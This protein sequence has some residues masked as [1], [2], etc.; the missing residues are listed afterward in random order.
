M[1]LKFCVCIEWLMK[2]LLFSGKSDPYCEVSMGTQ[3][4]RTKVIQVR[5]VLTLTYSLDASRVLRVNNDKWLL[6]IHI[7]YY[8]MFEYKSTGS[9]CNFCASAP[10]PCACTC[11]LLGL[12]EVFT[13]RF[14][15]YCT[16]DDFR[17][18]LLASWK[19]QFNY[20]IGIW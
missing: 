1:L 6:L 2:T 20:F 13:P 15:S 18:E 9:S 5:P 10:A 14:A 12:L 17:N 3:E 8:L 7:V 19:M 11:I 4:H 16:H